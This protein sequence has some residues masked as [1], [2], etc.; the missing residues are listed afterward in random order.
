MSAGAGPVPTTTTAGAAGP[1]ELHYAPH[2]PWIIAVV[3]TIATFM[4][5]LDTSIANVALPHIA[6]N[7]G[8]S[9]TDSTW[10][11]TSYLV[12][13]AVVLPATAWLSSVLGRKNY[14]MLAVA[15]FTLS[16]LLCGLAPSLG[17]LVV[18]RLLQG[19]GG[20]GLQPSTQA[21]LVD[22]FPPRQ[23][24][25]GMAVY[26]MTV[27]V[28][29]VIGP[30][31]G[32]WI[33]DNFSWR[34]IFFINVPVGALSLLLS[35]RFIEDPPYLPR[36]RGR[37][38]FRADFIGLG[39]VALALGTL[40]IVLDLGE[41]YDWLSS[42]FITI[43]AVL[44]VGAFV[45]AFFWEWQTKDA[46]VDLR[47]LL[48]DRN[49]G[50]SSLNMLIFGCVLFGSTVLLP[51]FMQTLLGYSAKQ[52]GMALSPG[53]IVIGVLMAPV[54]WMVSR[55]DVRGLI[56][57]G[58]LVIAYSLWLM[59]GFDLSVDFR[60]IVVARMIQGLGLAFIFVPVNTIAYAY[61]P[62]EQRNSAS[63]LIS[64]ARNVGGSVGIGVISAVLARRTQ[65]HQAHLVT[66]LTPYDR[67][68]TAE[69]AR[70]TAA[71]GRQTGD[72]VRAAALA[73]GVIAQIAGRQAQMLAFI[74]LF[75]ALAVGILLLIPVVLLTRRPRHEGAGGV[76]ME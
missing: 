3:A 76:A 75:E 17:V 50:L 23:R 54:G 53:G 14:Y 60:T 11:L 45:V 66:H 39:L 49:L 35:S 57:V 28:A 8:A 6:G 65:V 5:V 12:A 16:S 59:S 36:R 47:L 70:L 73:R 15:V 37:G 32:G 63:S 55:I 71:F 68:Y 33:T 69:L 10:V 1:G 26:G 62:R 43:C 40:Q 4:E 30:T 72:P 38:R 48:G 58:V 74:E 42:R 27:V 29:P 13:N 22:T 41:R 18:F 67:A 21:I 25:M 34:W 56:V 46:M 61:V 20:G 31:L 44:C 51:V 19:L 52:S 24:G 9:V 2:N 64:I 7:L